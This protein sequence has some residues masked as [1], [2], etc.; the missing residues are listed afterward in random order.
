M[1]STTA[2]DGITWLSC[3]ENL[4][5]EAS[6]TRYS[7]ILPHVRPIFPEHNWDS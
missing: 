3:T 2:M 6:V 4:E 7:N 5:V 1:A